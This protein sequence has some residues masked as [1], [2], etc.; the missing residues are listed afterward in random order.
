MDMNFKGN[1]II[2]GLLLGRAGSIGFP[3]KNTYPV[4]GRPLMVYPMLAG[5]NSKY[6]DKLFFSTD[7]EDYKQIG[8]SYGLEI[9]DRPP[10][11]ATK[12]ALGEDAFVHGFKI[13]K[14]FYQKHGKEL[15]LLVLFFCNSA[16]ILSETIDEGI[17]IL[18]N[19]PEYDSA[20][21]ASPYNMW[22]PLRARRETK[23]GLLQPFVPFETFGDP[24]TLNCDR[25][26]QGD[27][28]FADM[29]VSIVRPHCLENLSKGLLPQK[30]MGQKI[31]PLKQ[32]GGCDVDFEWQ[33]PGVVYWLEKHGFTEKTTPYDFK[34]LKLPV[35]EHL[36]G[37]IRIKNPQE[38]RLQFL[39]LDKN[40]NLISLPAETLNKI[41]EL[42]SADFISAYPELDDLYSKLSKRLGI[43]QECLYITAGSDAGIKATFEVFV[44]P[45]DK[46]LLLEPTYAMYNVYV[47]MFQA[48]AVKIK[49]AN[50]LTL[51]YK[52]IINQIEAEKPK[53]VCLA[54]PNSPTGTIIVPD[55][56]EQIISRAAIN[57]VIV[58][59]DE[60]YFPYYEKTAINLINRYP[61]LLITRTFSKASGIA[62]ARIGYIVAGKHMIESLHKVRPMYE[63]N[64]FGVK[65]TEF[66]LDNPQ[67]TE[68]NIRQTSNGKK[69]LEQSLRAL[70]MIFFESHANFINIKVGSYEKSVQIERQMRHD[71][72]LIKSGIQNTPLEDSIRVS[73][74]NIEQM[75]IFIEAFIKINSGIG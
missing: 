31:F 63:A 59:I 15:E 49:Y 46:V 30:W 73:I 70:N 27:V 37:L 71:G 7:A 44:K 74:G 43:P 62:A 26:S 21:T 54:N 56:I 75:K 20:I 66:L 65:L 28:W 68:N 18:R 13:I 52:T 24:R 38:S 42:I 29:G 33:V 34:N 11:L 10:E 25:D 40:E 1:K 58:L 64:A 72:V 17:E 67:I 9:I 8:R 5:L 19:R 14:E 2:A 6:I 12:E 69:Y 50:D 39:R 3:G 35:K 23:E 60:A 61:N 22:S 48:E 45:S 16:T 51:D 57:G 32:S 53:L 47:K 36:S 4:L 55:E 41:K